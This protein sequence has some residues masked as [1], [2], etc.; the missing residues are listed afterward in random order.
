MSEQ[1]MRENLFVIAQTYASAR[2]LA[3]TTVSKEFH[4]N[5]LFLEKYIKGELSPTTGQPISL[6][7]RT[8]FQMIDKF[9]AKWPTA[10]KW[11]ETRDIQRPLRVPYVAPANPPKRDDDGRFLGKKVQKRVRGA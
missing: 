11:P 9:R 4:G 7:I 5:Q 3:L 1:I 10:V 8:Y 2:G 6:T